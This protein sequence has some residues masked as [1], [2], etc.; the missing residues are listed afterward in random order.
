MTIAAVV[1]DLGG[2][3]FRYHP[4][5]RFEGFAGNFQDFAPSSDHFGFMRTAMHYMLV[6][7]LDD[8]PVP[9]HARVQVLHPHALEHRVPWPYE[10]Q[11]THRESASPPTTRTLLYAP[12][13]R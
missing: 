11:L 12:L 5:R 9:Q 7:P 8:D 3:V 10:D 4:E 1:F 6:A 2:V 13:F